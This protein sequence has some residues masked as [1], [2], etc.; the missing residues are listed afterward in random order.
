MGHK[1]MLLLAMV[2]FLFCPVFVISSQES[3]GGDP[4]FLD[5]EESSWQPVE[6]IPGGKWKPIRT[7]PENGAVTALVQFDAGVVEKAHH[8]SKGH[9]IYVVS[10]AKVVE[11]L[12]AEKDYTLSEGMY[13]YT[14]AGDVHRIRYLTRCTFLFVTDGPFDILWDEEASTDP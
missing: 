11:N 14:P 6:D 9:M 1:S 5:T 4:I 7:D 10:G 8:H 12:T 2:S 13:L 3:S